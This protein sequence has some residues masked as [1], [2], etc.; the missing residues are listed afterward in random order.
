LL[1][2]AIDKF[3]DRLDKDDKEIKAYENDDEHE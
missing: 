2:V 3:T 1:L